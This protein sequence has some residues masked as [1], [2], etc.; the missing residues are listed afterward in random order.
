M[1]IGKA[2]ATLLIWG[3]NI[4]L[5]AQPNLLPSSSLRVHVFD[6]GQGDS[7]LLTSPSGKHVLVDGGPGLSI[8]PQLAKALPFFDRTIAL[9][10]IT[11]PNIDHLT[12]IP[13]ILQHYDVRAALLPRTNSYLPLYQEI[14][15]ILIQRG[16]P[17]LY[18]HPDTD[19][20]LGDGVTIDILWPPE[21]P[22]NEWSNNLN[23]TSVVVRAIFGDQ[24]IL[25]TGDIE[26]KAEM[27]ILASGAD[28]H[29]TI[30]KV[31]HHGSKTS[32]STGFLLAGSPQAA[33]ISVGRNN[34]YKHPHPSIISRLLHFGI[35]VTT[36]AENG[37]IVE[38]FYGFTRP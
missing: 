37:T 13:D 21:S 8:A 12:A 1:P 22:K 31:A 10:I 4:S 16:I 35:T 33:V 34:M 30:L 17:I 6:V 38:E 29:T 28:I 15:G 3:M 9:L 2:L 11:H 25:L 27:A 32:T 24:S 5:F 14:L 7:I 19:I 36:T 18:P 23:N 26:E 20:N